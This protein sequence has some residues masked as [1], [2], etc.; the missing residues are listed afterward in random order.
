MFVKALNFKPRP[1]PASI[2]HK[3]K[4][5]NAPCTIQFPPIRM[6]MAPSG[7]SSTIT[8]L[9]MIPWAFWYS[10]ILL[11]VLLILTPPELPFPLPLPLGWSSASS[12]SSSSLWLPGPFFPGLPGP[13]PLPPC[14]SAGLLLEGDVGEVGEEPEPA[15][16]N[17]F[18][19]EEMDA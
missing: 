15:A 11:A 8:T 2:A 17:G 7:K 10:V 1:K 14:P 13:Y 12:S 3:L 18:E 19:S 5:C 6:S 4:I 16:M 9:K